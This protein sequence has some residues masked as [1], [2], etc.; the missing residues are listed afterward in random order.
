MRS[1][2]A[3]TLFLLTFVVGC[4]TSGGGD[5][6]GSAPTGQD[7]ASTNGGGTGSSDQNDDPS[8][9]PDADNNGN[10]S[11]DSDDLPVAFRLDGMWEDNGRPI[12]INQNGA[13]VVATYSFAYICDLD[14]GPVPLSEVPDP[15]ANTDSTFFNFDGTLNNG[16]DV[17][18]GDIITGETSIC[19]FGDRSGIVLADLT[20]TVVDENTMSGDWEIDADGDGE[21]DYAGSIMLTR[22]Q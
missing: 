7:D 14:T 20:L 11:D 15:G 17:L 2:I 12:V 18:P 1:T 3:S 10:D 8:D 6:D 9:D 5:G 22:E 21:L 19:L 4:A 13:Q 16:E